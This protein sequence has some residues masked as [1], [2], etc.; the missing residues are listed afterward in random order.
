MKK[1]LF[2]LIFIA[3]LLLSIYY[4]TLKQGFHEDEYYTYY[5]TNR[6]LGLYQPDREWQDRQ[7]V[8]DEFVVR[9]GEGFNYG[10][11]KLVQSWDVHPPFYYFVFHTIC[12]FVPGVFTKWTGIITNLIAFA[13]SFLFFA[14]IMKELEAPLW[15][16]LLTLIFWG[17]NPQTVS[18]NMLIRM[19]AWLSAAIFAC[20]FFHVRLL[21]LYDSG[22][23]DYRKLFLTALLPIM[24]CSYLGFLIQY[25]YIFFFVSIGFGCF[26]YLLFI[27]KDIRFTAVYVFS[28]AL[29]L[30]LAIITYPSALSHMF[31]GYRGGDAAGSLF[32]FGSTWMRIAFFT[33]LL[34]DFVFGGGLVAVFFLLLVGILLKMTARNRKRE[35]GREMSYKWLI[36]I[37]AALGYFL[38]TSKSALLVGAASNRYE[39]PIYGLL[40]FLILEDAYYVLKDFDNMGFRYIFAAVI[41]ALLLKGHIYDHRVLFLYPEDKEKTAYAAENSGEV[42]VVMFNPAT[43]QNVWRLTNELL[44]YPKVFYM[45]EENLAPL[46]DPDVTSAT[47][48][49]LYAADND[50]QSEAFK[51]L[52]TSCKNLTSMTV[53]F[54]EDMWTSYEI[55]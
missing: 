19:Y 23:K 18:C 11:V 54:T 51:N 45:D 25:F 46:T 13:I 41:I 30:G 37:F 39:M 10:L 55:N 33:G 52:T 34:N 9:E 5:S 43:P 15:V 31:G 32:D 1:Y 26:V 4:G 42:A 6:S 47:K 8:L 27:R 49:I 20:A 2:S 36:L 28:C 29:S 17:L 14:L 21:R 7:T 24:A 48:I 16:E 12:S 53:K 44:Q 35:K 38:L 22:T 3:A 50:L 40:I